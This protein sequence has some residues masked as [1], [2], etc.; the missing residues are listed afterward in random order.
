MGLRLAQGARL[1][2]HG[3]R[4]MAGRLDALEGVLR[5]FVIS[6]FLEGEKEL[7]RESCRG[8]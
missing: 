4:Q 3:K 7:I 8:L 1:G 2:Q 5:R 6:T